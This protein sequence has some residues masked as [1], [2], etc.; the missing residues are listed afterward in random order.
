MT[1]KERQ[2]RQFAEQLHL[3]NDR[4]N[5]FVGL[6]PVTFASKKHPSRAKRKALERRFY[7]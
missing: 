2:R 6:R 7:E 1:K 4:G 5:T 3:E